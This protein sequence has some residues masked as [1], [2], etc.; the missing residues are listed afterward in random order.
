MPLFDSIC[1]SFATISASGFSYNSIGD[2][3]AINPKF[4]WIGAIFMF[5]AGVNFTLQYKIYIQKHFKSLK[6]STEFMTYLYLILFVSAFAI[7]SLIFNNHYDFTV[8]IRSGFYQ[9][10]SIITST[11]SILPDFTHWSQSTQI[12]IFILM[13]IGGSAGSTSGGIKVVRVVIV[14]KYLWNEIIKIIHP[15]ATL[16][17]KLGKMVISEDIL[18][19]IL[20]FVIFYFLILI[21]STVGVCAI[22]NNL[23]L[24]IMGSASTLGNVNSVFTYG[25]HAGFEELSP[26]TKIIFMINMLVGR[27][28]LIP[29]IAM[30]HPDFWKFNI[31]KEQ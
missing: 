17:I 14:L 23:T 9:V 11:G 6:N 13:L 12:L 5:L 30:L 7:I 20:A 21:I 31:K 28:E 16:Q 1:N 10:I 4:L 15:N 29:F 18:K 24:G 25:G 22:E 26:F 2:T 19:Q 3:G 27:L 8:A